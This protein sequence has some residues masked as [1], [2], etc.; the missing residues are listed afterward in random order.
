MKSGVVDALFGATL[1]RAPRPAH[2]EPRL[3]VLLYKGV[4]IKNK[5]TSV[6][7]LAE[8][9]LCA[10]HPAHLHDQPRIDDKLLGSL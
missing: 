10:S 2:T 7:G 5:N 1:F 6:V 4:D 3:T 9:M 8:K